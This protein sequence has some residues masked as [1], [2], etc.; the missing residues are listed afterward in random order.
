LIR[1]SFV[2]LLQFRASILT[3]SRSSS[4]VQMHRNMNT[5]AVPIKL[6]PIEMPSDCFGI[7]VYSDSFES[8]DN[9]DKFIANAEIKSEP[10]TRLTTC[11]LQAEPHQLSSIAR[12]QANVD[13]DAGSTALDLP[14]FDCHSLSSSLSLDSSPPTS[15]PDLELPTYTYC[16]QI[17]APDDSAATILSLPF[18]LFNVTN[19]MP[20]DLTISSST[21]IDL[22]TQSINDGIDLADLSTVQSITP[23]KTSR[24]IKSKGSRAPK[25]SKAPKNAKQ[26]KRKLPNNSG[27]GLLSVA[28]SAAIDGINAISY[29]SSLPGHTTIHTSNE[30]VSAEWLQSTSGARNLEPLDID[31][32]VPYMEL[33]P[34]ELFDDL[35]LVVTEHT[36]ELADQSNDTGFDCAVSSSA[37]SNFS[38]SPSSSSMSS[39]SSTSSSSSS[40]NNCLSASADQLTSSTSGRIRWKKLLKNQ[41]LTPDD[42]ERRRNLANKQERRRML[43]LNKALDQLREVIP[44]EF[45]QKHEARLLAPKKLSKIKTL[46]IAIEYI[47]HLSCH[48]NQP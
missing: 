9:Y 3:I 42:L 28:K 29:V 14:S 25:A 17:A 39:S 44:A 45:V 38:S 43:K 35:P 16:M 46:R 32:L 22:H 47:A 41:S 24:A 11:L 31:Q 33:I 37:F 12:Y 19:H 20:S 1:S 10:G 27:A 48:L 15:Q 30:P 40:S 5:T 26:T 34:H 6:E 4:A 36:A 2:T 7:S 13:H 21:T 8:T 18:D 23:L